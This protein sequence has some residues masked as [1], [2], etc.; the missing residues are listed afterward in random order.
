[1]MSRLRTVLS[2]A[3]V[4]SLFA[5]SACDVAEPSLDE[6]DG[7]V[8]S[9]EPR[10]G[11]LE[12]LVDL[13]LSYAAYR[14]GPQ[15]QIDIEPQ[16]WCIDGNSYETKVQDVYRYCDEQLSEWVDVYFTCI[17]HYDCVGGFWV[18][19]WSACDAGEPPPQWVPS[20]EPCD[21]TP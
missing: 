11:A 4:T 20:G 1:M 9:V 19:G 14:D 13:Q 2:T 10:A 12:E 17:K 18:E 21:P 5:A 3:L 6:L 15:L 7:P 16:Q 8:S